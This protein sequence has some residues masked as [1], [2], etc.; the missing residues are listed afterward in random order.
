MK[1]LPFKGVT[2]F[3][4]MRYVSEKGGAWIAG[5][6]YASNQRPDLSFHTIYG[7]GSAYLLGP[8]WG[9]RVV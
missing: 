1:P 5:L 6:N 4:N 3:T 7:D 9:M 2:K 8:F